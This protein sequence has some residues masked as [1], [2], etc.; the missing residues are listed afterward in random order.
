MREVSTSPAIAITGAPSLRA[1]I[2]PLNRWVTPGPAVPHTATGLPVSTAGDY[3]SG[4]H[5]PPPGQ[6]RLLEE[7]LRVC[8]ETDESRV[9]KWTDALSRA[10]RAPGKRA[11]RL[12]APYRGLASF[13][14][15]DAPFFFGR[16]E[17]T[18]QLVAMATG[19]AAVSGVPLTVVG[20]SGS[21]K[22]SLLRAGLV[23]RLLGDVAA[24][25][26]PE[27]PLD[28]R[29]GVERTLRFDTDHAVD[30]IEHAHDRLAPPIEGLEDPP[31]LDVPADG[32]GLPAGRGVVHQG[33]PG[34]LAHRD[35]SGRAEN[36]AP[37][38]V[39]VRRGEAG[40]GY[41]DRAVV[42]A[43]DHDRGARTIESDL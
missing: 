20:P 6:P 9:R 28:G 25:G 26:S 4:S 11:G 2:S 8:G 12:T 24:D 31:E 3:F 34:G 15:E 27:E 10:R 40:L 13:E 23:P 37:Y 41:G 30:V 32:A 29:V 33:G 42:E 5:L 22:S 19:T 16:A 14:P 7:I 17:A 35:H 39:P 18:E 1:S 21:G 43:D 38:V 36:L